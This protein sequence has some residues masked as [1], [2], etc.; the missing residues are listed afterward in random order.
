MGPTMGGSTDAEVTE[1]CNQAAMAITAGLSGDAGAS[2]SCGLSISG[3]GC[4]AS[5]DVEAMCEAQCSGASCT[6]PDVT[7][8]CDPG[9]LQR[10]VRRD[11]GTFMCSAYVQGR[12]RRS[13]PSVRGPARPTAPAPA[14]PRCGPVAAIDG[15]TAMFTG[16]RRQLQRHVHRERRHGDAEHRQVRGHLQRQVR[17][18]LHDH[19]RQPGALQ[20]HV[21]QQPATATATSPRW[22]GVQLRRNGHLLVHAGVGCTGMGDG[23]QVRGG[24]HPAVLHRNAQLL[25]ERRVPRRLPG[26]SAGEPRCARLPRCSSTSR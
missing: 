13:R 17:R 19:R 20:R 12:V 4:T 16:M 25:G 15:C 24:G 22:R 11:R 10:A 5:A 23:A 7:V 26:A 21:Q 1:A 14:P 3:G 18:G 9:S 8:S 6:P 2:A